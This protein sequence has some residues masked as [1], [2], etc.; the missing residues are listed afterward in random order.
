MFGEHS[1]ANHTY[2]ERVEHTEYA[3]SFTSL[4]RTLKHLNN[5]SKW[6]S[7]NFENRWKWSRGALSNWQNRFRSLPRS[8]IWHNEVFRRNYPPL[9]FRWPPGEKAEILKIVENGPE[10][11][12]PIGKM[13]WTTKHID[14]DPFQGQI[15]D[16]MRYLEE[17]TPLFAS[18]DPP[19]KK[20]KFW[21]SLEMV[22]R[23]LI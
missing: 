21:K 13:D 7:R 2:D 23:G 11:S 18:G 6:K 8:N 19:V 5:Y 12:Y 17:I 22:K 9:C 3:I 16:R 10:A 20:L 1:T 15:F 14:L 4:E